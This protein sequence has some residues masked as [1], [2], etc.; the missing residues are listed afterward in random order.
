M[1]PGTTTFEDA[2]L[3]V[4]RS[5]ADP[6]SGVTLTTTAVS[7]RGATVSV[8]FAGTSLAAPSASPTNAPSPTAS[9]SSTS[10]PSP[11]P[12]PTS[13]PR[14]T[15]T[16]TPAPTAT[17]RPETV[18]TV[19]APKN[20]RAF[21]LDGRRVRVRWEASAGPVVGYRVIR[22]GVRVGYTTTLRFYER[23][24]RDVTRAVYVVRARD[25]WGNLGPR[26]RSYT[27]YLR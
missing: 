14:P 19:T 15:A 9:P 13:T 7:S 25:R 26:S 23:V 8:Q 11:T 4:G 5:F 2:P 17:P 20:V 18:L 12:S 27:P 22:N 1:T 16:A 21:R 3:A 6:L 24:P 10:S